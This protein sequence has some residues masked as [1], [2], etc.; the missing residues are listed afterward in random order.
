VPKL[1]TKKS[2]AKRLKVTKK[3][4][5][6]KAKAGRRHLLSTKS[7][8]RKRSLRRKSALPKTVAGMVK[9]GLPYS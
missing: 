6:L 4:K 3:K 2:F 9:K 8:K 7:R 1:K 5:V